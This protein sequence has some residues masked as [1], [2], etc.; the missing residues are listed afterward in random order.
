MN[1]KNTITFGGQV[2]H[3]DFLP[4]RT[5]VVSNGETITNSLPDKY[6]FENSIFIS[7]DQEIS[8]RISL[9]Y[10]LRYSNFS[11]IGTGTRLTLG[12]TTAGIERPVK[13]TE[14]IPSGK[15]LASYGNFEPRF[16]MK[17][18]LD[19]ASSIKVSYNRM[20]QYVHLLSNTQA[21]VPLD[22]WTPTS[23]NIKPQIGDQ[24][25]GG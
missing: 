10:G 9:T 23:N 12:D 3:Y 13:Q 5:R 8:K 11:N 14:A 18:E 7:N 24:I 17:Y 21:S 20:A 25:A 4:G 19:D 22:V 1:D 6:A 16:S 2:L 15:I